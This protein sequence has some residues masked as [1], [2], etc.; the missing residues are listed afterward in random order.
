MSPAAALAAASSRVAASTPAGGPQR[1]Q[2]ALHGRRPAP[3]SA[4]VAQ[5]PEVGSEVGGRLRVEERHELLGQRPAHDAVA[6]AARAD[7]E[8]P[9]LQGRVRGVGRRVA[10][11]ARVLGDDLAAGAD[12]RD[13]EGPHRDGDLARGV[14]GARGV[15]VLA[16]GPERALLVALP[17][18]PRD[19]CER[20]R[21]QRRERRAV[22]LE[23]LGLGRALAV[24]RLAVGELQARAE[25]PPVV[26]LHVPDLRD[27]DEEVA[28]E[29]SDLVLHGA[30]LVPR[31]GVGEAVVEAVVRGEA[32]EELGG[33]DLRADPAADLGCVVEDG[34]HRHAA[35][36]LERVP[37]PLADALGGLAPEDLGEPD[38]GVRE[39]DRE[40]VAAGDDAAHAEVRLPEVDLALAREPVEQEEPLR[41]AGRR[42]RRRAPRACA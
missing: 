16:A 29:R 9:Q 36:E 26:G 33:D 37:E 14:G 25:Q 5:R 2:R 42:A 30:L 38:V 31:V 7:R 8:Q 32:P 39:R 23:E 19:A 11:L 10:P 6:P 40:E 24:V 12:D 1:A 18:E 17:G 15:A 27:R 20:R 28:P 22:V 41:L 21:G 34:A 13:V 4:H 3:P 35:E